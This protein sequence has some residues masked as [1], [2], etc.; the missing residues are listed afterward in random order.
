MFLK[1]AGRGGEEKKSLQIQLINEDKEQVRQ[2]RLNP[3]NKDSDGWMRQREED[4]KKKIERK[5]SHT[6]ANLGTLVGHERNQMSHTP[7]FRMNA[8]KW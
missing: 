8:S 4:G 2:L 5:K 3:S 7:A 1:R 6:I